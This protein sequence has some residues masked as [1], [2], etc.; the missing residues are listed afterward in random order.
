MVQIGQS[1]QTLR[2]YV[3][4][5]HHLFEKSQVFLGY[6]KW[7]ESCVFTIVLMQREAME[8]ETAVEHIILHCYF[9]NDLAETREPLKGAHTL[10]S[11]DRR[12]PR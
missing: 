9:T 11:K 10:N 8:T 1:L 5:Y 2:F 6:F 4:F 12:D 7:N 3:C